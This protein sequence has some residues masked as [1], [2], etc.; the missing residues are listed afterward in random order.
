MKLSELIVALTKV[1]GN[2][3]SSDPDVEIWLPGSRIYLTSVMPGKRAGWTADD[4]VLIEGNL[5]PGSA[6]DAESTL[7]QREGKL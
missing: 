1:Q 7:D 2:I 6:L 5:R 3:P 4:V